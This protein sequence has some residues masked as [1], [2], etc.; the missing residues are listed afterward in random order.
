MPSRE[1]HLGQAE[2]NAEFAGDLLNRDWSAACADWAVSALFYSAVH[3][4]DAYLATMD[5]HPETHTI[6]GNWVA[7]TDKLKPVYSNYEELRNRSE[8]ARYKCRHFK[9]AQVRAIRS[10]DHDPLQEHVLRLLGTR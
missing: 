9:P 3:L 8:D 6:R 7:R 5:A 2:G 1:S 10:S 4:V